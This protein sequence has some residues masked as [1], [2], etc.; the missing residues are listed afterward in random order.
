MENLT[1]QE[2]IDRNFVNSVK[3]ELLKIWKDGKLPK[4]RKNGL[5]STSISE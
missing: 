4:H 1:E 3:R 2:K 5:S